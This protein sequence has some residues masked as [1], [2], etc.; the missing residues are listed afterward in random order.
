MKS[1]KG[2]RGWEDCRICVTEGKMYGLGDTLKTRGYEKKRKKKGMKGS[3]ERSDSQEA[4][5]SKCSQEVPESIRSALRQDLQMIQT[6][7]H[8]TEFPNFLRSC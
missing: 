4:R 5:S 1:Q 2:A 3:A 6:T 8:Q 7:L